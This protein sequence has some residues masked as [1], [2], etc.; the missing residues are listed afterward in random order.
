MCT[1]CHKQYTVA[2][3]TLCE[4]SHLALNKWLFAVYLMMVSKEG[5][6]RTSNPSRD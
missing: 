6:K 3:G 1:D 4:R 2:V 5:H